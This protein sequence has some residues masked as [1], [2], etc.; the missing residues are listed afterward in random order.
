MK[1]LKIYPLFYRHYREQRHIVHSKERPKHPS[2]KI[3]RVERKLIE[4]GRG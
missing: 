3:S 1:S 2:L 4:K